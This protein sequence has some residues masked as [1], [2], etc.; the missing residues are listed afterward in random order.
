MN[1]H[2]QR[3]LLLALAC[4]AAGAAWLPWWIGPTLGGVR[5]SVYDRVLPALALLWVVAQVG[6]GERSGPLG[7]TSRRILA[8][9]VVVGCVWAAWRFAELC[10]PTLRWAAGFDGFFSAAFVEAHVPVALRWA[11]AP[12]ALGTIGVLAAVALG[13]WT[14]G[15]PSQ[16][17]GR[18]GCIGL[19][20]SGFGLWLLGGFGAFYTTRDL[21]ASIEP[22]HTTLAEFIL[23]GRATDADWV[24]AR[25]TVEDLAEN[26]V[27]LAHT[28]LV[29]YRPMC[30]VTL[31]GD[32]IVAK[33]FWVID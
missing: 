15:A 24:W 9:W 16:V 11:P 1:L 8:G 21:C 13:R 2:P 4:L 29:F 23:A 18:A 27:T 25:A 5:G 6:I 17:A 14:P 31:E 10:L 32:R 20:V 30:T 22:G 12:V 33:N 26:E 19:A 7:R 3:A 28:W